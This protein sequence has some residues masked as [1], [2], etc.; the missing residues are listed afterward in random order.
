MLRSLHISNYILIDSLEIAFPEGLII[1][2]GQTGAGKSI[3]LGALSLILGGKADAS[4]IRDSDDN[5][6]LEAEFEVEDEATAAWLDECE[7]VEWDGRSLVI[8]RVIYGS[9]RSRAFVNDS[10]VQLSLLSELSSRLMD[11]HSQHQSLK[12]TDHSFQLSVLD[13][14]AGNSGLLAQCSALWRRL[15]SLN[16]GLADLDAKMSRMSEEREYNEAMFAKLNEAALV[17]GELEQ[18]EAEQK[19]LANSGEIMQMLHALEELNEPTGDDAQGLSRAVKESCRLLQKLGH[20]MSPAAALADRLETLRVELE[21]IFSDVDALGGGL[22]FSP[23][24][25]E[26]VEERM[27]LLYDLLRKHKCAN[28]DELI[29]KRNSLSELLYD[30][31]AL[32][33]RR[34]ELTA[35]IADVRHSLEKC[36]AELHDRRLSAA[37]P[38]ASRITEGLHFLELDKSLF[39]IGIDAAPLSAAGSD[40]VTFRFD[41]SGRMPTDVAKCVSGGEIS[42][43]VL[44]LKSVMAEYTGMPTMIFDEIDSGVSG[45]VADKMGSMICEMGRHMQVIAITHLPQVAAKGEAHFLVT[46]SS[47]GTSSMV[48]RLDAEQRVMEIARMLSGSSI[49]PAAVAN[50][51]ELLG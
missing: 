45:S 47:D 4:V 11:I 40:A 43:I 36:S 51:R 44:C 15:Q 35:E 17:S 48:T 1:I 37:A 24:R 29:A 22:D 21:D 30:S 6:V 9:G 3:L 50:A 27:S 14:F 28:V 19:Q 8:R 10:P 7:D 41:A 23:G 20:Y 49:T 39:E 12:L 26:A 34:E 16:Q 2:T 38:L 42:R 33:S 31:S 5:C 25:L 32:E 46:K 18:L 13:W